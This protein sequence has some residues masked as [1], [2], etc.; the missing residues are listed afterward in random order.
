MSGQP[1]GKRFASFGCKL[2]AKQ[3]MLSNGL[4][5]Y[6]IED[7]EVPIV[8]ISLATRG[9]QHAS[10]E[11]KAGAFST[12]LQIID[13]YLVFYICCVHCYHARPNMHIIYWPGALIV[14]RLVI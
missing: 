2:N 1:S 6:M 5:V 7:H 13:L 14:K 8:K 9:G 10:P 12:F 4:K 11:D 3:V